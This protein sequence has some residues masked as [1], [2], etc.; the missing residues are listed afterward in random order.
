[1]QASKI[2]LPEFDKNKIINR[3]DELRSLTMLSPEIFG[4][5]IIEICKE[6]GIAVV[7]TPYISKTYLNGATRWVNGTPIIQLNL[8]FSY[9]DTFWFTFFHELGHILFH[10]K[11]D[12]FVEFNISQSKETEKEKEADTFAEEKLIPVDIFNNFC[13]RETISI[14]SAKEFANEQGIHH[15]IV[16]G[17]LAHAS[18]IDWKK[19]SLYRQKLVLSKSDY[20]P[21]NN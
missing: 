19:A 2:N 21:N 3:I 5:K 11:T 8:R 4:E 15:S 9:S 12:E 10:G 13:D 20:E 1:L 17:R 18:L 7:Y 6:A 16:F 14:Q